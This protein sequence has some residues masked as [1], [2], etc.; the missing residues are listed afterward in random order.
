MAGSRIFAHSKAM[1]TGRTRG[2][3][4]GGRR[5]SSGRCGRCPSRHKS[6]VPQAQEGARR[7]LMERGIRRVCIETPCCLS[8]GGCRFKAGARR[9]LA[10][11]RLKPCFFWERRCSA[12]TIGGLLTRASGKPGDLE[13]RGTARGALRLRPEMAH[14]KFSNQAFRNIVLPPKRSN[15]SQGEAPGRAQKSEA[16]RVHRSVARK[17]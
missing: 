4:K 8:L 9:R 15:R 14:S 2:T 3:R 12:R 16:T 11:P 17:A 7:F 13:R 1:A 5:D 10:P 6:L